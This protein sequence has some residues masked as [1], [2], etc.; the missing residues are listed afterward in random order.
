[1]DDA[2]V[3]HLTPPSQVGDISNREL[4]EE[5]KRLTAAVEAQTKYLRDWRMPARNAALASIAG[6]LTATL[7]ISLLVQLFQPFKSI[8]A[9][10]P[11]I[12]KVS[13]ALDQDGRK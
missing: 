4:L 10:R 6:V 3:Q 13:D 1:V 7:G 11:L 8:E 5:V 9:L 2:P 12:E